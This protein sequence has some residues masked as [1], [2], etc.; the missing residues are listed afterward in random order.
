MICDGI[1]DYRRGG[2]KADDTDTARRSKET[3]RQQRCEKE[4]K[5]NEQ[6]DY[7]EKNSHREIA[8]SKGLKR[9]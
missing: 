7:D 1:E 4:W 3:R 9:K 8:E 6:L 5:G 2:M